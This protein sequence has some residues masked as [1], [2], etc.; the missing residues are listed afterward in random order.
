MFL[1]TDNLVAEVTTVSFSGCSILLFSLLQGT[2]GLRLPEHYSPVFLQIHQK[3]RPGVQVI[4]NWD[5]GIV[6]ERIITLPS[7]GNIS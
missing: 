6:H 2:W 7:V 5:P 4:D 1:S 3:E